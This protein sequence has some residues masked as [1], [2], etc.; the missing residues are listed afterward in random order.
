M[1]KEEQEEVCM[2][3]TDLSDRIGALSER[4]SRMTVKLPDYVARPIMKQVDVIDE[5]VQEIADSIME[6]E[7]ELSADD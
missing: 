4:I 2:E 5:Q 6:Y 1:N 3:I 7:M